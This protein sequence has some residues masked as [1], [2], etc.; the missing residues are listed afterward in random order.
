MHEEVPSLKQSD[1]LINDKS[2]R[3]VL[4]KK[5]T[6][7]MVAAGKD[8]IGFIAIN[9]DTPVQQQQLRPCGGLTSL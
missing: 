6:N 1:N 8:Y 7:D 5:D 4:R 2:Q 3:D 9:D